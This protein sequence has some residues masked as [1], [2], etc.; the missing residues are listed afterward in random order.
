M[1]RIAAV[2]VRIALGSFIFAVVLVWVRS[3]GGAL[4]ALI[5][6]ALSAWPLA[7]FVVWKPRTGDAMPERSI[8]LKLQLVLLA[9]ALG[10][11]LVVYVFGLVGLVVVG[12]LSSLALALAS[13]RFT[14]RKA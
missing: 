1:R 7:R 9:L 10:C 3:W 11:F 2:A 13:R 14:R 6:G 4:A 5:V 8:M 12:A